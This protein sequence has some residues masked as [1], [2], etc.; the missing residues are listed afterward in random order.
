M[1]TPVF[2]QLRGLLDANGARYRVLEHIPEGRC[3]DVSAIRGNKL[4]EANKALVVRAKRAAERRYFLLCL[5]ADQ[6]A[7]FKALKGYDDVRL[8]TPA[9]VERLTGC[10]PGCVPP[11]SFHPELSVIADPLILKND[12]F[13]FNA[14]RLDASIQLSSEDYVRIVQP[15][16]RTIALPA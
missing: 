6:R 14:G 1:A 9:E 10:V 8:C 12:M 5:R 4:E 7:D 13:W 16:I 15:E 11:F 3:A 2:Q